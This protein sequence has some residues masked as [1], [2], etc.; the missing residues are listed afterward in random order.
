MTS[1][2]L[3]AEDKGGGL[4]RWMVL[5]EWTIFACLTALVLG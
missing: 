5:I 3:M 4:G 1:R 2:A